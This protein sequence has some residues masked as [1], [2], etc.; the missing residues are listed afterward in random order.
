MRYLFALACAATLASCAPA[1]TAPLA[2]KV[3]VTTSSGGPQC[4]AVTEKQ[5]AALFD[6]WNASLATLDPAKVTANYR[7][8]ALLLPTVS[9]RPRSTP[10]QINDYFVHFL[11]KHPTGKINRRTI[12]IGCNVAVDAG[13]YTFT[14]E[15]GHEVTGRYSFVYEYENGEWLIASHHSSA[16]PQDLK[17]EPWAE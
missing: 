10:E 2:Q 1:A 6:R 4:Q 3:T 12:R 9:N 14:F 11:E 8:D 13:V 15:D 16:M 7:P 17:L 5:V